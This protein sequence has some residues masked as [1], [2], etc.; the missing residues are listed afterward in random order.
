MAGYD[1]GIN[2]SAGY[3]YLF[4]TFLS[5]QIMYIN[6]V[7]YN[8]SDETTKKELCFPRV[9]PYISM[10]GLFVKV[11]KSVSVAF[12][13]LSATS[14]AWFDTSGYNLALSGH[15]MLMSLLCLKMTKFKKVRV[16]AISINITLGLTRLVVSIVD[17]AIN[18]DNYKTLTA[19][20]IAT[21]ATHMI[22][23]FLANALMDIHLA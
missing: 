21:Y 20:T 1:E 18:K 4:F 11:G 7:R 12:K 9:L 14:S 23:L 5:A 2:C 3:I 10:C 13:G 22:S 6:T 19:P 15:M 16:L 17:N 8:S